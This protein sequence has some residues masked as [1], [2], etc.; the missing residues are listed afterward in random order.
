[1]QHIQ[2]ELLKNHAMFA[3]RIAKVENLDMDNLFQRLPYNYVLLSQEGKDTDNYHIHGVV[4]VERHKE[5]NDEY[6]KTQLRQNIK[7][8]YPS[9]I[10][11]KCLTVKEA[12]SKKQLMK[13]TLKEGN[14]V[15]KGFD[16]TLI[17]K[18]FKL[19][20]VK[21]NLKVKITDNEE[22]LLLNEI[23][24]ETFLINHIDILV[25]H[26]QSLYNNHIKAYANRFLIKSGNMSPSVYV[27]K[28]F[29]EYY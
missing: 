9:A 23:D 13:Y 25:S 19:S 17:D 11:N 16:K 6:L 28:Y 21:E 26:G 3:I 1:M 4:L 20:N 5:R 7:D 2:F 27:Q 8:L 15:Y 24:Y 14:Y 18:L 10:G 22:R 12:R 29:L